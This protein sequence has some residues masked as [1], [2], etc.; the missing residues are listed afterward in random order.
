M[1]NSS[2]KRA[3]TGADGKIRYAVVGLGYISQ[4]AL[5]PAF[6]HAKKNSEL[7]A[8]VSGDPEKLKQL[9]KQYGVKRTYAYE[10]YEE[11][12]NSGE[13]DA[14]Y[15][16]LPNHMH[17]DYTVR[18]VRAGVHVLCEKPMAVTEEDCEVM[19]AEARDNGVK[20]MIA[21]R[22]HFEEANL[23]AIELVQSGKLGDVRLFHSTFTQQVQEGNIRVRRETGG[24]TLYDIGIYC[25]NA[26][27]YLFRAEPG[28]VFAVTANNGEE[29]FR[30]V[31]EM[32]TA[33]LRFPGDRL[34]T[35]TCSFST[36]PV[37]AY[38]VVGSKGDLR[39][40]PAYDFVGE[41]K[42]YLTI[43]GKTKE[44][45]FSSRDQFAPQLLYFSD[46]VLNDK[47]PEP[48]GE[49]GLAD[50][51]VIRALYQS[52]QDGKPVRL[53][54]FE[55]QHRPTPDQEIEKPPVKKPKLVNAS[56]PSGAK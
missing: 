36:A 12:L 22:L 39:L 6:A 9:S 26:T 25:I 41:L 46:C 33:V 17:R 50:V 19:I 13:V 54:P 27:R 48:S 1:A 16:G 28:E 7:A 2:P 30:E 35:F 3:K 18:A 53:E 38:R 56:S 11:C 40:E 37:S 47:E 15:I 52:A 14:V 32:A 34:A 43:E 20:L 8:L 4:V 5:L 45:K 42:H 29:R 10:Q 55:R 24:G 23:K 31:E 44:T 51:R 21:Y 49:E